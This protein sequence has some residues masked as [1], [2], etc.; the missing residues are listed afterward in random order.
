MQTA[1]LSQ[2]EVIST[3]NTQ[4]GQCTGGV[5][6]GFVAS[7]LP[8]V[9]TLSGPAG[10]IDYGINNPVFSIA[11]LCPGSY[12]IVFVDNHGCSDSKVFEVGECGD[13]ELSFKQVG[14]NDC[15][16][17]GT[18]LETTIIK[19]ENLQFS[20]S[21]GSTNKDLLDIGIG[22]YRLTVVDDHGC[23]KTYENL[24]IGNIAIIDFVYPDNEGMADGSITVE[25]TGM[26]AP[27][28]LELY[29]PEN[30]LI[31]S[32]TEAE[33][34]SGQ[35]TFHSD[36]V[37]KSI[38]F[39]KYKIVVT[40]ANGCQTILYQVFNGTDCSLKIKLENL[41]YESERCWDNVTMGCEQNKCSIEGSYD[42]EFELKL[43]GD[44]TNIEFYD[45]IIIQKY[46]AWDSNYNLIDKTFLLY[47]GKGKNKFINIHHLGWVAQVDEIIVSISDPY[48][49][50]C[51]KE[52][53]FK[54]SYCCRL[55]NT[56]CPNLKDKHCIPPTSQADAEVITQIKSINI[57]CVE[58]IILGHPGR[59]HF[60]I[61]LIN[62]SYLGDFEMIDPNGN[63]ILDYSI[64]Q[65]FYV[66]IKFDNLIIPG[67]YSFKIKQ[68]CGQEYFAFQSIYLCNDIET[69][70]K[71]NSTSCFDQI[72]NG[73]ETGI[74]CGGP[75]C[76]PCNNETSCNPVCV[77][78]EKCI[79]NECMLPLCGCII[80]LKDSPNEINYIKSLF[81]DLSPGSIIKISEYVVDPGIN[82]IFKQDVYTLWE[83]CGS[84]ISNNSFKLI[85]NSPVTIIIN[86]ELCGGN[87]F[88]ARIKLICE[89][90]TPCS[91]NETCVNGQCYELCV[92]GECPD[93]YTCTTID[94]VEV[95]VPFVPECE[96][97][98]DCP[99]GEHCENGTCVPDIIECDFNNDGISDCSE[100]EKCI[101][102]ECVE[103]ENCCST[104]SDCPQNYF[105]KS[106]E[107]HQCPQFAF[108]VQWA[109]NNDCRFELWI[110]TSV[111]D[112]DVIGSINIY[113]FNLITEQT[114]SIFKS[115]NHPF[116]N[117]YKEKYSGIVPN[118]SEW[119]LRIQ[120]SIENCNP[121]PLFINSDSDGNPIGWTANCISNIPFDKNEI[122]N[123]SQKVE[124]ENF[125]VS[126]NTNELNHSNQNDDVSIFPNPFKNTFTIQSKLEKIKEIKVQNVIGSIVFHN[127][128]QQPALQTDIIFDTQPAGIYFVTVISADNKTWTLKIIK[129]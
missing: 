46:K 109:N 92:N 117:N 56:D 121:Y 5:N 42:G 38:R 125:Q 101:E 16:Y 51:H 94:G 78:P 76:P 88:N 75:F 12:S 59:I 102:N 70:Q 83:N 114:I 116:L 39:G 90:P 30:V 27:Y 63:E 110:T 19:G 120:I 6:L 15:G 52:L 23:F 2:V 113:L 35:F 126:T 119:N 93:G 44:N 26:D 33:F 64:S 45:M 8:G 1:L 58:D 69:C 122:Y 112:V 13:I 80:D 34:I 124:N 67:S 95:C 77:A 29:D 20:W 104:N 22:T 98:G 41:K 115:D 40:D 72:Q 107:C 65:D 32:T 36:N 43:I 9:L 89:C 108:E 50:S 91:L 74:D 118:G 84:S 82:V 54:F 37:E 96:D 17:P 111:S 47:E 128:L 61:N 57:F 11:D 10:I 3:K 7:E 31:H 81:H 55:N 14:K 86:S 62:P 127:I 105:C 66:I 99:A 87:A 68:G 103:I 73:N 28:K 48:N 60:Y 4:S 97:D 25:A 24:Q 100:C 129:S 71:C 21:D 53:K 106:H 85:N 18:G 49:L 123:S 79:N